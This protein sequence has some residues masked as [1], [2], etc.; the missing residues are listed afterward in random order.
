VNVNNLADYQALD[1][2]KT[3][4]GTWMIPADAI[5]NQEWD[6]ITELTKAALIAAA[7]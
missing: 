6:R 5:D 2:V 3:V 7:D 4:G 1:C